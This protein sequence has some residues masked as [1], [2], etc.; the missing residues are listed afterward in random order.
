M[1]VGAADVDLKPADLLLFVKLFAGVCVILHRKT[2]DVCH[3][4]LVEAL[5]QFGKLLADDLL[6]PGVLQT[7]CIDHARIAL[8]NTRRGI[9]E[10]GIL[11]CS[12][13]GERA[14][15]VDV[16]QLGKF[17]AVAKASAGRDDGVIQ[18]NAAQIYF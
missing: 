9:A 3:D 7:N 5:F 4:R 6:H 14:K 18:F 17:V 10:A 12:L 13:K 8:G 16:I 11:G 1:H 2:A 15:T